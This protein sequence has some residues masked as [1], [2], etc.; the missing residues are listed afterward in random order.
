MK[1][2]DISHNELDYAALVNGH[3]S[4]M[5]VLTSIDLCDNRL[6]EEHAREVGIGIGFGIEIEIV[7]IGID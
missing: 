7:G 1:K 6:N 3:L 5:D 2:L 4:E